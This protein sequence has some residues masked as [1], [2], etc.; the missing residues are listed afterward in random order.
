K[1]T[2]GRVLDA[3]NDF[4]KGGQTLG[5]SLFAVSVLAKRLCRV[6]AHHSRARDSACDCGDREQKDGATRER[7]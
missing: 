6:N 1:R 2:H 5:S 4:P 3:R 7:D